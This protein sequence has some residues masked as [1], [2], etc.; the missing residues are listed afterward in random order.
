ME[1]LRAF[2]WP[3]N[4]RQLAR[5]VERAIALSPG[6]AIVLADL[7][8]EIT[9]AYVEL[10]GAAPVGD[11]TL[12]EWSGRYARL[13]LDRCSG[14]KRRACDIL[15]ISYH[16]LQSYLDYPASAETAVANAT[17]DAMLEVEARLHEQA[18]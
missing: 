18:S 5:I 12:R 11:L 9:R 13:V 3:G 6:P 16:T 17:C 8:Q 1:A 2:D 10:S 15:G 14:N 4:V 7:P